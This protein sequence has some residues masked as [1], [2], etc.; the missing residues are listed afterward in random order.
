MLWLPSASQEVQ[1]LCACD[2]VCRMCWIALKACASTMCP[3][4][5][6]LPLTQVRRRPG[7]LVDCTPAGGQQKRVAKEDPVSSNCSGGFVV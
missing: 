5:C 1:L 7:G 2:V 4:M 3:T 6:A